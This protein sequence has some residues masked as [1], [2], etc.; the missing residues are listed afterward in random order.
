MES[1][2]PGKQRKELYNAPLHKRRKW[3][4]SHLEENL[5]LK[6]DKRAV[7]KVIGL[8]EKNIDCIFS[9]EYKKYVEKAQKKLSKYVQK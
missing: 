1:I 7:W 6:Y 4:S 3:L 9:K 5:L 2:K 8:L